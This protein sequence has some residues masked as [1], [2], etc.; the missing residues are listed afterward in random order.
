[1]KI[2]KFMF[3]ALANDSNKNKN[4]NI[5]K[6]HIHMSTG[7]PST[8]TSM[9]DMYRSLV[10]KLR[11]KGSDSDSDH[12][13]R[14]AY[15]IGVG[16]GPGSGKSTTAEAVAHLLNDIQPGT[17]IVIPMDGW[18]W[19]QDKLLE[20]HGQEHGYKRRGAPWTY[21][22]GACVDDLTQAK[23]TGHASLPVY[24]RETSNPVPHGLQ[25]TPNHKFVLVEGNYVLHK[26]H[27]EWG[28]LDTLW[29][30]RW[31]VKCPTR[32]EQVDRLVQRSLQTWHEPKIQLWGPGAQGAR[33]R[34]EFND[35]Q[36]MDIVSYCEVH[37]DHVII[38]Q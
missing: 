14:S 7:A 27:D 24:S 8:T 16:G 36:N 34:A 20:S 31:F 22:V 29:D 26:D 3:M 5:N 30:E 13:G 25:L 19:P 33:N 18:H 6:S 10:E 4:K 35:V 37:A 12:P 11:L 9:T 2:L 15:W 23:A 28:K 17:A 1:M 21:D 38:S 32:D